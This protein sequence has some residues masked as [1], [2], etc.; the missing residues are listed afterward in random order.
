MIISRAEI[1]SAVAA[2]KTVKRKPSVD[3]LAF[4]TAD[5]FDRSELATAMA[6]F[7][8]A[9][10]SEPFYREDLVDDLGRRIIEGRYFVPSE[11][12]VDKLLGRL[13]VEAA[14]A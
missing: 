11:E 13:I 3:T 10:A 1:R 9:V 8:Y 12:I 14:T 6:E 2:Y 7:A 5:S 4:D